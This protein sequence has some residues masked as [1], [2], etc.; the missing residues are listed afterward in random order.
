MNKTCA[1][2]SGGSISNLE[3]INASF[4]IAC[5]KGY[6]YAIDNNIIPNLFVG[7]FDSYNGPVDNKTVVLDLPKEKDDTD[8]L[9]AIKYAI[10]NGYKEINLYCALGGRLDHLLAN[11]ESCAYACSKGVDIKIFDDNN[12][13]YFISN[14][15]IIIKE[16]KGYSLSLLSITDKCTNVSINNVK[17]PLNKYELTNKFPIGVSNEWI[18]DA[19]IKVEDGILLVILSKI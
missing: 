9:A 13:L 18:G 16:K 19:S 1:I 7:D 4:V 10:A 14:K 11:I 3:S 5:D 12:I 2:I 15:E 17:Y 6:K 8:T